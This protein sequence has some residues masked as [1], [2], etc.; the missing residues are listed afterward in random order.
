MAK[1]KVGDIVVLGRHMRPGARQPH[2]WTMQM[3][4]YVGTRATLIGRD[5]LYW[6]VDTNTWVW[7]EEYFGNQCPCKLSSCLNRKHRKQIKEG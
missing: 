4:Q 3:D 7:E 2:N 6:Q 5:Q 1:Y